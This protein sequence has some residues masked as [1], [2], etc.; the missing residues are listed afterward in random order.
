MDSIKHNIFIYILLYDD[1]FVRQAI[2]QIYSAPN[3]HR[4]FFVRSTIDDFKRKS[5]LHES[6]RLISKS[7]MVFFQKFYKSL[8]KRTN[9][10]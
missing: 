3:R 7:E 10:V 2:R 4:A 9:L 8:V 5:V 6:L 1:F